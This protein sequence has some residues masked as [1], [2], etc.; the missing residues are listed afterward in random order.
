MIFVL[1][2]INIQHTKINGFD[3]VMKVMALDE[4][5]LSG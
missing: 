1:N 4:S 3:I 2:D 5:A